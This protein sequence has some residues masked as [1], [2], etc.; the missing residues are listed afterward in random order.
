MKIRLAIINTAISEAKKSNVVRGK[1]GAVLFTSNGNIV[2]S[3]HNSIFLGYVDKK[4]FTIHAEEFLLMKACKLNII[5]RMKNEKLYMLVVRY[6]K[7][8]DTLSSAK[9]CPK[10]QYLISKAGIY[11]VYFSNVNGLIEEMEK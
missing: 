10:C 7:E 4:K 8:D 9:P 2:V 6:R 5:N 1:I 11:K 3:A